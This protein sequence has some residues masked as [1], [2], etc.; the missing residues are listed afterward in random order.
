MKSQ[1]TKEFESHGAK[2]YSASTLLASSASLGWST[3]SAELRSHG[4]KETPLTAPGPVE[5]RLAIV[6][7]ENGLVRRIGA[8]QYQE[9]VPFTGPAWL[10]PAEIGDDILAITASIPKAMHLLLPKRLFDRLNEDF[11]L[12][13]AA[14]HSIRYLSGIR[15]DVISAIAHSLLCEMMSE[16]AAGRMYAE[17]ASMMLAAHLVCKHSDSRPGKSITATSPQIDQVR[18]RRVVDFISTHLADEITL[19]ELSRVAG[20]STFHFARMFTRAIGVSPCRYVSR[21]RLEKATAEI[22]AGKL[23]LVQIA[24][25]ARFSSQASFTRAFVRATGVTPGGYRRLRC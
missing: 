23:S 2:T 4:I 3:L 12:P 9:T 13:H 18:I 8:G 7:N 20:L 16:S 10:N 14:A 24:L 22:A 25:N 19:A 11:S 5:V 6:G 1:Q 15:D 21:L 17:A